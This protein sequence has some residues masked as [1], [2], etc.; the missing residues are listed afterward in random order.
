[1]LLCVELGNSEMID[2]WTYDADDNM[3]GAEFIVID[4]AIDLSNLPIV[5]C[6]PVY[7]WLR[8]QVR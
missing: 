1:M 6:S 4:N 3:V 5:H 2:S 7:Y 8:Y